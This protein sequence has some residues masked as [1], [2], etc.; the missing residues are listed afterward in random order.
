[1]MLNILTFFMTACLSFSAFANDINHNLYS[2][3]TATGMKVGAV[4]GVLPDIE[5]D[6][7][8]VS[9]STPICDYIEIHAMIEDDGIFRMRKIEN[10]PVHAGNKNI[11]EPSGYHLM[12]MNLTEPLEAKQSFPLTLVFEKSG[13]K[14]VTI[15]VISRKRK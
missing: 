4:F 6:D 1:M 10:L 13:K 14:I 5:I 12:L 9:A 2:H 3:P 15:P 11:L 8:L 7:K